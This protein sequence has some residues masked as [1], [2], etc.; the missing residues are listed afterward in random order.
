MRSLR[1][2]IAVF[3][4]FATLRVSA[5]N[6]VLTIGSVTAPSGTMLVPVYL[7]DVSGTRL[8][9]DRATGQRIQA[10][11]FR[12]RFSP[13][14]RVTNASFVRAGALAKTPLYDKTL[15]GTDWLGYVASFAE[16][17]NA[18]AFTSNGAAPG[19]L[20]GYLSLTASGSVGTVIDVT[21]DERAAVLSSQDASITETVANDGLQLK[22]GTITLAAACTSPS[23][24]ASVTGTAGACVLGTGGTANVSISNATGVTYQW[25]YRTVHNGSITPIS[26]AIGSAYVIAGSDF[27]GA[28]TKYLVVTA[29][30]PCGPQIIS[31]ELPINITSMPPVTLTASTG[32]F[33]GS[34]DNYASVEDQGAGATYAWSVTNGTITSGQGT[35]HIRYTAGTSGTIT[36]GATVTKNGCSAPA[37]PSAVVSIVARPAG[38]TMFYMV[39]PCRIIDTRNPVGPYG[40]PA[41][42]SGSSRQITVAG[43]CGIP[44][45]AK[46]ITANVTAISPA[47]SGFLALYASDL[48]WPGTTTV[49]YRLGK[50]RANNSNIGISS[51]GRI[52]V[53]NEGTTLHYVIDVTGYFK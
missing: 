24:S 13:A 7:R 32:V 2:L 23:V 5:A 33:A 16:S 40:G 35:R 52:T 49:S 45:G 4:A 29:T 14:G 48:A 9:V 26:G 39:T 53:K 46:S 41:A 44:A 3:F 47:A 37:S 27:D 43:V 1:A 31:N 34:T 30:A 20:I 21:L 10:L 8:G 50:T 25:G 17:N 36:I 38:A 11:G 42:A 6:D 19:N 28:G 18:L 22:S 12:V 15:S 51:D